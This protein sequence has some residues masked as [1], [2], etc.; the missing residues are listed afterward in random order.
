MITEDPAAGRAGT[1]AGSDLR[2]IVSARL[3]RAGLTY[4]SPELEQIRQHNAT[5]LAHHQWA[6]DAH[7][8]RAERIRAGGAL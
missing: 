1:T 4:G 5:M 3:L 7:E 8:A 6:V 2:S